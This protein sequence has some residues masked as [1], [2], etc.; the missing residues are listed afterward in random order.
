MLFY[1]LYSKLMNQLFFLYRIS[2]IT[3]LMSCTTYPIFLNIR[4]KRMYHFIYIYQTDLK[5]IEFYFN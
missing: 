1:F 2:N 5:N 4:F 3:I